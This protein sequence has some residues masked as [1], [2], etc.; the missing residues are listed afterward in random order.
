MMY[1]QIIFQEEIQPVMNTERDSGDR[2]NR[3]F[4]ISDID[5][6]QFIWYIMINKWVIN[7]W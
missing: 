7:G 6:Y 3:F 5:K 4:F 1:C 2:E